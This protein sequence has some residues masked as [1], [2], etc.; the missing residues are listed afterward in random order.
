MTICV[1]SS[2][3]ASTDYKGDKLLK[4]LTTTEVQDILQLNERQAKALMRTAGFPSIRI[5][6]EYRVEES[7]FEEWVGTTKAVKLDYSKC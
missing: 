5:G 3:G 6:R 7:K 4:F 2:S 1:G